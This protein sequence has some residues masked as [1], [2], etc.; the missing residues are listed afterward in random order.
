MARGDW[1]GDS[2]IDLLIVLREFGKS[3]RDVLRDMNDLRG[4]MRESREYRE[5]VSA[6][7]YPILEIYPVESDDAGRFRRMYLDALTEG[8]VV[9]E[10]EGFLTDL[11]RRFKE[12][13]KEMGAR[14]IEIPMKG[15]YWVLGELEAGEVL[16]L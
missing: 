8:I 15:H 3:R 6:G 13:L 1:D 9:F 12:R 16:E 4:E 5:C 14:R 11:I 2:D 7:Q 10:R